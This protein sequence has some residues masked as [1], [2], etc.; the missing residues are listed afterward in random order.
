MAVKAGAN[1]GIF[2]FLFS[3]RLAPRHQQAEFG[4]RGIGLKYTGN[5]SFVNN[6]DAVADRAEFFEFAGN[7]DNRSALVLFVKTQGIKNDFFRAD[8]NAPGR[9]GNKE[10]F[11]VKGEGL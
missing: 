2:Q 4:G 3:R 11:W 9:L 5:L 6:G 10:E 8:I 1:A 7:H